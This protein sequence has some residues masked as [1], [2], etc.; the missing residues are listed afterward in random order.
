ML[1][2]LL[3]IAINIFAVTN[4]FAVNNDL[5]SGTESPVSVTST[6]DGK[7][8]LYQ[9]STVIIK[10]NDSEAGEVI[11][12]K[13]VPDKKCKWDKSAW[14]I[15]GPANYY[16]GKYR[17]LIFVDNGTGPDLRQISIFD[18]NNHIQQ[19]N[20]SYVA[21]VNINKNQFTYW[22]PA[23]T[24]ATKENCDKFAEASKTGLTPQIQKQ[25]QVN[26]LNSSLSAIPAKKVRCEL[27]Q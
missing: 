26:L 24:I 4:A 15:T 1:K 20:D 18:I 5:L 7:C 10:S 16:F 6:S 14:K 27:S 17:N 22:Q 12:I 9:D 21:P 3:V 11:L 13:V 25:I 2:P 8:Y 19:F 23:A